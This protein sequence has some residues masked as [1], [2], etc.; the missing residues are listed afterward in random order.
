[1]LH[2]TFVRGAQT[3]KGEHFPPFGDGDQLFKVVLR[4]AFVKMTF[5]IS[6]PSVMKSTCVV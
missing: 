1:M 6:P 3:I 5:G 2:R 4:I